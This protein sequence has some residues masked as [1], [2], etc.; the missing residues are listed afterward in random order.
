[1][2]KEYHLN[3]AVNRFGLNKKRSVGDLMELLS[4]AMPLTLEEWEEYYYTHGRSRDQVA[5][6]GQ[7]LSRKLRDVLIHELE[8]ITEEDCITYMRELLL[9][10]TFEGHRTRFY[11][12]RQQ[13]LDRTGK[14]FNFLP[15]HR[16]DW[17][18]RDHR[19]DYYHHDA[20]KDLLIGLKAC[21]DSMRMSQNMFA[22]QALEEIEA[23]H[24]QLSD[25]AAGHFYILYFHGTSEHCTIENPEIL[26]EI[27]TL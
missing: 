24:R 14:L 13:I 26:D 9:Q 18:F 2:A 7:E 10:K 4:L 1:M 17:R 15:E 12:L 11:T 27:A 3:A 22:R 23:T 20:T 19:I 25:K 16:E 21:P 6:I 8:S 5:A